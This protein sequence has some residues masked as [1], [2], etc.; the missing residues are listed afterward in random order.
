LDWSDA[1]RLFYDHPICLPL[2]FDDVCHPTNYSN[3]NLIDQA[4]K[5]QAGIA[6]D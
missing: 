1:D 2:G 4:I 3:L 5:I 6:D